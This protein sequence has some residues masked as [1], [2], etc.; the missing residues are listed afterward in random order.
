MDL[1]IYE[2]SILQLTDPTAV[3]LNVAFKACHP[4]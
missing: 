4:S 2:L 1:T 3:R